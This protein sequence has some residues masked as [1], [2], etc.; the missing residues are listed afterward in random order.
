MGN[1]LSSPATLYQSNE[2]ISIAAVFANRD[3]V[4]NSNCPTGKNKIFLK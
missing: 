2:K 4:V 1:S 3:Y